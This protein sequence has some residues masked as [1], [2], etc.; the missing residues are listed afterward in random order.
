MPMPKVGDQATIDKTITERDVA[1]FGEVSTDMNPVHFDEEYAKTTRFGGRIAHGMLGASL[2]SAVIGTKLPGPGS[3][4]LGQTLRFTAPV[5]LGDTVTAEVTVTA[6]REDKP[7]VTLA[8]VVRT[9]AGEVAVT[10]EATVLVQ[11]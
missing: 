3:I 4:Y 10:G 9:S 8:T 5:R 2:L 1:L 7:I 11:G 6:V